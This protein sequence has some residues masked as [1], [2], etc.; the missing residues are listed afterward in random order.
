MLLQNGDLTTLARAENWIA[1]TVGGSS[2]I[3]QQL[4]SAMSNQIYSK[5]NRGRVYSR[6]V[7]ST[8]NGTGN[9]QLVLPAYP[10]TSILSV[11]MDAAVVP[12]S[13][14]PDPTTGVAAGLNTGWGYR[15]VPWGGNLPGENTVL[16]F[17]NGGWWPGVQNVKVTYQAGYLIAAE[18]QNV[19]S[20]MGPYTITV[21]QPQ[22]VWSRDNGVVY[23]SSGVALIPVASSPT[24]GE[25]IPPL[26]TNPGTLY[27]LKFRFWCCTFDFLFIHS[28]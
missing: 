8:F 22:G 10:V 18:A 1:G 20:G 24:A 14:L 2:T 17:Q 13:P 6:Q 28:Q 27:A 26:D 5:L 15:F 16:E 3:L 23:A 12:A 7:I 19:P 11:Q 21:D 25:Y 4:I 9:Y